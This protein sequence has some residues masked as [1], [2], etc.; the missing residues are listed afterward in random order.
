MSASRMGPL[1]SALAAFAA[2]IAAYGHG[3]RAA[4]IERVAF[5]SADE[6]ATSL[7]G[8]LLRPAGAGPFPAVVL[9]H[10]CGGLFNRDGGLTK[11][12]ADWAQRFVAA[13][14][15]VL[16]PD[17][18][19]PRGVKSICSD[20]DRVVSPDGRAKDALGAAAWLR[21]QRFVVPARVAAMGWSNGGSTVLRLVAESNVAN[22]YA[23]AV[24]FYPGCKSIAEQ[25]RWEA[26]VP[27]LIEIGE[28]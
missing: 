6:N 18:F 7:T 1:V 13:G 26:R 23:A 20:R 8:Q 2:V 27:L 9:L 24:A 25:S 11:R 15:V 19:T 16:F 14:Y 12:H 10:G 28:A 22:V 5:R 3:A 21:T 17:S 4:D